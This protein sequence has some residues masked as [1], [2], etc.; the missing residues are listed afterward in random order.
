MARTTPVLLASRRVHDGARPDREHAPR[1]STSSIE[2]SSTRR[3]TRS[4]RPRGARSLK[5]TEPTSAASFAARAPPLLSKTRRRCTA[6][7]VPFPS[8][9]P[10]GRQRTC[11]FA[12]RAP[13]NVAT[14]S[15]AIRARLRGAALRGR[16]A[17]VAAFKTTRAFAVTGI[18][19]RARAP[20]RTI[21]GYLWWALGQL[22]QDRRGRVGAGYGSG[23]GA[24][25]VVI[26]R[27]GFAGYVARPVRSIRTR[28]PA[29]E[30]ID[31]TDP[32]FT[33]VGA[34]LNGRL[35]HGE[36]WKEIEKLFL[37]DAR[38]S[39]A[40]AFARQCEPGQRENVA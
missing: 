6:A 38:V 7:Q 31:Q 36:S 9:L 34:A 37:R 21:N 5:P 24:R 18:R 1:L 15:D 39:D 14:R 2:V 13:V 23:D 11:L 4:T 33:L 22:G 16:Q 26:D 29:L 25:I 10:G 27:R 8:G 17:D 28:Y 19:I 40:A 30:L 12:D 32:S 3:S 35:G 20:A